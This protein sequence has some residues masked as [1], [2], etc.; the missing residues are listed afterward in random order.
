MAIFEMGLVMLPVSLCKTLLSQG[1]LN[2][3]QQ[4]F[5]LVVWGLSFLCGPRAV[6]YTFLHYNPLLIPS[7]FL[8]NGVVFLWECGAAA[9]VWSQASFPVTQLTFAWCFI[10]RDYVYFTS[11]LRFSLESGKK[12]PKNNIQSLWHYPVLPVFTIIQNLAH[13]TESVNSVCV[14]QRLCG[15]VSRVF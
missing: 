1:Q 8:R 11:A 4:L 6:R 13:Y 15:E 10:E 14:F 9:A 12:Y 5:S 2:T 3:F 7:H